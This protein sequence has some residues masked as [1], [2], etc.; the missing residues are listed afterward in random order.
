[1]LKECNDYGIMNPNGRSDG[2]PQ[3]LP[4]RMDNE[5]IGSVEQYPAR[6]VRQQ[7]RVAQTYD[8]NPKGDDEDEDGDCKD[9]WKRDSEARNDDWRGEASTDVAESFGGAESGLIGAQAAAASVAA[10]ALTAAVYVFSLFVAASPC[11]ATTDALSFTLSIRN[12]D[13]APLL[14]A[15]TSDAGTVTR[16]V[17]NAAYL[18]FDGLEKGAEYEL[19]IVNAE[20]GET[21][22]RKSYVTASEDPYR[23]SVEDAELSPDGTFSFHLSVEGLQ[24]SD[25]YTLTVMDADGKPLLVVDGADADAFFAVPTGADT[26]DADPESADT[27]GAE[28]DGENAESADTTGADAKSAAMPFV[29]VSV[30]GMTFMPHVW[31]DSAP[32]APPDASGTPQEPDA[33]EETPQEPDVPEETPTDPP[34]EQPQ[35]PPDAPEEPSA[36]PDAPP[37]SPPTPETPAQTPATPETPTPTPETPAQTPVTPTPTPETP[38]PTPQEQAQTPVTPEPTPQDVPEET[39]EPE[40]PSEPEPV[41]AKWTWNEEH[42]AAT[43][44]FPDPDDPESVITAE[45]TVTESVTDATCTEDGERTYAASVVGPDGETYA[46]TRKETIPAKGHNYER[47]NL[48]AGSA[49]SYADY[50]CSQCGDVFR[51]SAAATEEPEA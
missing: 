28:T 50:I 10:V 22:Y 46:D 1:M 49:A 20:T 23:V 3:Y 21:L 7:I 26:A 36:T 12:P 27:T 51:M 11:S 42:T 29:T 41:Q 31:E 40:T 33:P 38:A 48:H 19:S 8:R 17:T 35:T 18:R 14:A 4:S 30:N 5:K 13:N 6:R 15:L 39:Q 45:A 37:E 16:D 47:V 43:V 34:E 44:E 32:D 9:D 24:K 2:I 25:F